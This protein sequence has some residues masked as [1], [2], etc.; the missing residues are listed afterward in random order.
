[1]N[2]QLIKKLKPEDVESMFD[3]KHLVLSAQSNISAMIYLEEQIKILEKQ[4]L[5]DSENSSAYQNLITVPGIGKILGLTIALETGNINRFKDVGNYVSYCR[6]VRSERFS[7]QKKKGNNNRKNGNKFLSWAF[8]EVAHKTRRYLPQADAFYKKK[9]IKKNK[10][11]AIKALSHKI[12]RAC[13]HMMKNEEPFNVERVFG[14][15]TKVLNN[16]CDSKPSR[17]LV[18]E[19]LAPIGQTVATNSL[20]R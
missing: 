14:K 18:K 3:N 20:N 2:A 5:K 9:S 10:I 7:N 8:I 6:C 19:P 11:V 13:F 17:G 1:M 15:T 12:A 16:G 4:I